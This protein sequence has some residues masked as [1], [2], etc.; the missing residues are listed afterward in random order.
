VEAEHIFP[1]GISRGAQVLPTAAGK[2]LLIQISFNSVETV[3]PQQS[4]DKDA[5]PK[6]SEK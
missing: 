1:A 5:F 3:P 2:K 4:T 6:P